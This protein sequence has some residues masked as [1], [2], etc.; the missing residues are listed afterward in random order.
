K[1]IEV[2]RF[3]TGCH[4]AVFSID[5]TVAPARELELI[6]R[7]EPAT[8]RRL[9]TS[10]HLPAQNR[11]VVSG[12]LA[13]SSIAQNGTD[14]TKSAASANRVM[15]ASPASVG[16]EGGPPGIQYQLGLIGPTCALPVWNSERLPER[17]SNPAKLVIFP[18][19]SKAAR[20]WQVM[21]DA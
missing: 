20:P 9:A 13:V 15:S 2:S 8:R 6:E 3:K 18:V 16:K 7:S 11:D 5:T 17:R 4:S 14:Q 10:V 19:M 12:G 1:T 21:H